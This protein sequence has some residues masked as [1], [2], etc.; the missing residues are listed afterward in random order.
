[1]ILQLYVARHGETDWNRQRRLQ[2][3]VDI[4]LNATGEEQ[5]REL[6]TKLA[7]TRFEHLYVSALKRAQ[8]TAKAFSE[9]IPRT[10]LEDLNERRLGDFEGAELHAMDANALATYQ[11]R[12]FAIDDVL[13]CG[14]SLRMHQE[15]VRRVVTTIRDRHVSGNILIVAHGATNALLLS[16]LQGRAPNDVADLRIDNGSVYR[17]TLDSGTLVDLVRL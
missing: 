6:A 5:A 1:M 3:S 11:A 4:P 14:E 17:A 15:R 7:D 8:Q 10:V 2:G 13:G 16:D 12:K 9:H